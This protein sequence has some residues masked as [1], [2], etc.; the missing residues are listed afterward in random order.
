[1]EMILIIKPSLFWNENNMHK[2]DLYRK[3]SLQGLHLKDCSLIFANYIK[4][5]PVEYEYFVTL[6]FSEKEKKALKKTYY[7]NGFEYVCCKFNKMIFRKKVNAIT[8][9]D[10]LLRQQQYNKCAKLN[11]IEFIVSIVMLIFHIIMG[12]LPIYDYDLYFY[13]LDF[14]T[15]VLLSEEAIFSYLEHRKNAPFYIGKSQKQHRV[16]VRLIQIISG[17]SFG[18]LYFLL[19]ADNQVI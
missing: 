5:E 14:A 11:L 10:I 1:M 18:I 9:K 3:Y 12:N 8:E 6:F 19:F 7:E 2:E 13:S 15:L 4:D 17:I 16:L